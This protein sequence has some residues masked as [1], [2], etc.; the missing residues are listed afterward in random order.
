MFSPEKGG[1]YDIFEKRPLDPRIL[2][3]CAQDIALLFQLETVMK[4][5]MGTVGK[6]WEDRI[7]RCSASRAAEAKS[8]SYDGP[9]GRHRASAP[10]F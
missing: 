6:N 5:T 2:A 3:Y 8:S 7:I 9:T 4:R 1:S 10:M